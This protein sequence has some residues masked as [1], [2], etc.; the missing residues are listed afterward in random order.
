MLSHLLPAEPVFFLIAQ[1]AT[2]T[3]KQRENAHFAG[4]S[5]RETRRVGNT[6]F[7]GRGGGDPTCWERTFRRVERGRPVVLG[8]HI[9]PGG[10]QRRRRP[11]RRRFATFNFYYTFN[12]LL[13]IQFFNTHSTFY[14]TFNFLLHIQLLLHIRFFATH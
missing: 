7:A 9:S 12:F 2:T 13:H 11:R 14:Y 3:T 5:G 1:Q 6:N 10:R 8:T 4:W